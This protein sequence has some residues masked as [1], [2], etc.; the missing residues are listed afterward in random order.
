MDTVSIAIKDLNVG[1]ILDG[2][3][4]RDIWRKLIS[5]EESLALKACSIGF[6]NKVKAKNKILKGS[7]I[8]EDDVFIVVNRRFVLLRK[9]MLEIHKNNLCERL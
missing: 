1:E 9:E 3:V 2:E 7:I 6:A 8:H 5:S 4:K